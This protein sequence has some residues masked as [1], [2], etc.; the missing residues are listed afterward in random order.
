MEHQTPA[1]KTFKNARHLFLL[2]LKALP[3]EAFTKSFGP[4]T[5]TVADIVYETNLVNE[6]VCLTMREEPLFDWPEG[7][8]TAPEDLRTKDVVIAAFEESSQ[9]HFETIASFS[10]DDLE[11]PLMN[12]GK[13]TTR[14]ER[15]KFM[16]LHMW[17]HSGQ[18]NFMQTLL[19]DSGFHWG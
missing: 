5:R 10:K 16:A 18:L 1:A 3:E 8:I 15:C 6:H 17:Y 13:E 14:D 12:E 9:K 4:A 11:A 2:D 7:W 19:G